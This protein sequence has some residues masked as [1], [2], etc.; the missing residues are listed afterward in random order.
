MTDT[1]RLVVVTDPKVEV[2]TASITESGRVSYTGVS[3]VLKPVVEEALAGKKDRR[4]AFRGLMK[5]G[6]SNAYLMIELK[7]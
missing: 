1:L 7:G 5:R 3:E 4:S 2:A 6:W